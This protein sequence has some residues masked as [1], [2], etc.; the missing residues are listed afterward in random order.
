MPIVQPKQPPLYR[1][2]NFQRSGFGYTD[3]SPGSDILLC[4]RWTS[5]W[6]KDG[7]PIYENDV[8]VFH[9]SYEMGWVYGVITRYGNS[10]GIRKLMKGLKILEIYWLQDCYVEG[11]IYQTKLES[12]ERIC[13]D[14]TKGFSSELAIYA[15]YKRG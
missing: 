2:W 7:K 5:F 15:D 3:E 10:F 8:V 9:Y 13:L 11:S 14:L 12:V 1:I 4:D 6:D